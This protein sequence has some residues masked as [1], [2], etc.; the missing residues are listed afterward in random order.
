MDQFNRLL[1]FL[2]DLEES[3][4]TYT[5]TKHTP[6]SITV[7]IDVPGQRWE[8]EFEDNNDLNVEV[9]ESKGGVGGEEKLRLLY[10]VHIL[11]E[12][13]DQKRTRFQIREGQTARDT[14]DS[15]RERELDDL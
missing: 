9:L 1:D 5:L 13:P 8:V 14:R 15:E 12:M 7:N 2:H 10:A 4:T 3:N 11:P 6:N